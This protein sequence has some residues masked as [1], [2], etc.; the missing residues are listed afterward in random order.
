MKYFMRARDL[1]V[2]CSLTVTF[3]LKFLM[4]Y[5]LYC[6]ASCAWKKSSSVTIEILNND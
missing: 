5:L 1:A 4:A 2:S 6:H 3:T